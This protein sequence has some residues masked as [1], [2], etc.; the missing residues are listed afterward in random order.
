MI[1]KLPF[2]TRRPEGAPLGEAYVVAAMRPDASGHDRG[3]ILLELNAEI[4]RARMIAMLTTAGFSPGSIWI[5]RGAADAGVRALVEVEGLVADDDQRLGALA[6][7]EAP[8]T[9]IG[10]FAVPLG[11]DV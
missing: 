10:G 3:L 7:L 4:S 5:R 8:A 11:E 9:V 6:R 1:A 2:W